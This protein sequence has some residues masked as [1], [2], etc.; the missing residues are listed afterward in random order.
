MGSF[1]NVD[2]SMYLFSNCYSLTSV[3]LSNF[4][5]SNYGNMNYMFSN[6]SQLTYL[7]LSNFNTSRV[8]YM[9]N[10]F[11][12]CSSLKTLIINFDTSRVNA[13]YSMFGLC[14]SLT[15]LNIS[16]FRTIRCNGFTGIFENDYGLDL[17]ITEGTCKNLVKEIPKYVNIHYIPNK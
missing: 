11:Y 1:K 4:N 3:N 13:M 12:N 10:M 16:S 9:N 6:C 5:T 8:H 15:S 2:E 17:Y 7:D 14:T